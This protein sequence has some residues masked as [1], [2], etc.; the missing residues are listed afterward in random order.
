[1]QHAPRRKVDRACLA[2][3]LLRASLSAAPGNSRYEGLS[4]LLPLVWNHWLLLFGGPPRQ[5]LPVAAALLV[6]CG[7]DSCVAL[8]LAW[9]PLPLS[10]PQQ[11]LPAFTCHLAQLPAS[12]EAQPELL[13]LCS[14]AQLGLVL[15]WRTLTPTLTWPAPRTGREPCRYGSDG[16]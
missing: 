14:N 8:G 11:C 3:W 16:C 15:W 6:P 9:C 1:M 13:A 4:F 10:V 5:A 7:E 2:A 12:C